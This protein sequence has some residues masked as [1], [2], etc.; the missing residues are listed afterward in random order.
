MN[1]PEE[2]TQ[3]RVFFERP[4]EPA[5]TVLHGA[6]QDPQSFW[7]YSRLMESR[8]T[9][10]CMA[11][12]YAGPAKLTER[13]ER[14][15]D[16]YHALLHHP[17]PGLLQIG[18]S[19]TSDGNPEKH[20]EHRVAEG[21]FDEYLRAGFQTLRKS[22][23]RAIIRIGY[24][25]NGPWNGYQPESYIRAFR[26]V[27]NLLRESGAKAATAWCAEAGKLENYMDFHP[28]DEYI[29]WWSIDIFATDHFDAAPEFLK[30]ALDRQRPVLIGESTPRRV[31]VLDGM[32][33]WN[34]WFAR[35]FALIRQW[36]HI[37]GFSY[38]NWNWASTKNWPDWGNARIE[39]NEEVLAAFQ[40]E[41]SDPLFQHLP[42]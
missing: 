14:F 2:S 23:H 41:L 5:S 4:L 29:D 16:D 1:P 36:P 26:H 17:H 10:P 30:A 8:Q 27:T 25:F 37:K 33:S 35:Y 21:E 6:G 42:S 3:P 12:A 20:Y 19:M 15:F 24:E 32:E 9:R 7:Q 11:M 38:I 13:L 34:R 40:Q 31:G 28:G 39:D 18:L 22:G